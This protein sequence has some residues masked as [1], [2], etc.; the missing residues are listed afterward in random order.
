MLESGSFY[1][2]LQH[3]SRIRIGLRAMGRT[4]PSMGRRMEESSGPVGVMQFDNA[5]G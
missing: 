2:P 5:L 4:G 1:L 3:P